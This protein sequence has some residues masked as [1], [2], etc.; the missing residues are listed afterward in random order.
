MLAETPTCI[1]VADPCEEARTTWKRL[2]A[3]GPTPVTFLEAS[4]IEEAG[5]LLARRPDCVLLDAQLA[6]NDAVAFLRDLRG[7]DGILDCPAMIL[8]GTDE[9]QL[10]HQSV[11]A[12]AQDHVVKGE[13]DAESLWRSV[14]YSI[15][16]HRL[17]QELHSANRRAHH[18]ATHCPLTGLPNRELLL[19][20]MTRAVAIARRQERLVALLFIDLDGFKSINDTFGHLAGDYVLRAVAER[21][22][23]NRRATDTL[24]RVGGDEF[25]ILLSNPTRATDAGRVA[26][27]VGDALTEPIDVNGSSLSVNASVGIAIFP[28]NADSAEELFQRADSTMHRVK[29]DG[30]GGVQFHSNR[31]TLSAHSRIDLERRLRDALAARRLE[32]RYLPRLDLR[33]RQVVAVEARP[34]W[35]DPALGVVPDGE[36]MALAAETDL[37]ERIG[38][39]QLR[40]ACHQARRWQAAGLHTIPISVRLAPRGLAKPDLPQ[41]LRESLVHSEVEGRSLELDLCDMDLGGDLAATVRVLEDFRS[42]GVRI[43]FSG[44]GRSPCSLVD[45]RRLPVDVMK[46]DRCFLSGLEDRE[47]NAAVTASII[48]L[49]RSLEAEP[50]ADGVETLEQVEFLM[51]HGC[52]TV[53]GT[54]LAPPLAERDVRRLLDDGADPL[55]VLEEKEA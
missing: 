42:L 55:E 5:R 19:D 25:A 49:A 28:D 13:A 51:E 46:I 18:L 43:A 37:I 8:T 17:V 7:R 47:R 36:L 2:L 10:E 35:S 54:L 6:E 23:R 53:Q 44:F 26:E 27:A 12:G 29:S 9:E 41:I 20:R 30:G 22:Q 24:A 50:V 33:R 1:L 4:S 16:R 52:S 14:R 38:M 34:R 32:A 40:Q 15:E 39:W 48:A 31:M 45:L 11:R 21:L 3:A